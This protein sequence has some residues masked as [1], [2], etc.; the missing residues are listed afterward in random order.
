MYY[1]ISQIS[2][3]IREAGIHNMSNAAATVEFDPYSH[4]IHDD[5]YPYYKALRDHDPVYFNKERGFWLLTK[6]DDVFNAFRDF[7]T[8]SNSK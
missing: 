5:P 6:Y 1:L 4:A 7:K 3:K 2:E 8:F